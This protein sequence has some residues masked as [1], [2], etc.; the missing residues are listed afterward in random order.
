MTA[1]SKDYGQKLYEGKAKIVFKAPGGTLIHF[2]KDSATAFNAQKKAEFEGKGALNIKMSTLVF[3]YLT[4][5]GVP[6]H[7]IRSIDERSFETKPLSMLPVE[8]VVRNRMAGSLA[9][10]LGEAEGAVLNPPL[11]EWYLKNDQK[12]DPQVSEDLLTSFYGV[13]AQDLTECRRQALRVNEVLSP[14]F[15]ELGLILVDFKLEFGKDT[16]GKVLLAD[17]F[18]PDTSRLWDKKTLEKLDKDRFRFDLGDLM[19]G[20]REVLARLEKRLAV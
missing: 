9:R 5:N 19:S 8:V 18:S 14:L 1:P 11:V 10:R 2:F 6:T 16:D 7:F 12:G 13:H 15:D 20:Y 17:E 3:R 4:Q